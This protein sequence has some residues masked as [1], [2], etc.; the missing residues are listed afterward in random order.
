MNCPH[1]IDVATYVLDALEPPDTDRMREHLPACPDCRLKYEE[2]R[3]LPALLRT[4]TMADVQDIVAPTELPQ[5]LCEA[6]ITRAA[7]RP[8]QRTRKRLLA[9]SAA[10]AILLAGV[11][12]G[13]VVHNHVPS[14]AE[15][16]TVSATDPHT[17]LHATLTLAAHT[18][19]TQIRLRLSSLDRPQRCVLVVSARDGRQDTA[20]TWMADYRGALDITGTTAIPPEQISHLDVIT[21]TGRRLVSLPPPPWPH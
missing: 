14:V 16:T 15:S 11:L 18:W 17:H 13:E 7:T 21:T 6:L 5:E 19:G 10:A 3:G 9:T 20:A 8:H 4:L 1:E 12:T 2:L